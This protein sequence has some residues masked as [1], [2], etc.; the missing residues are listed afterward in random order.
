MMRKLAD[1]AKVCHVE[2]SP[3]L[4]AE[5]GP[6]RLAVLVEGATEPPFHNEHW[7]RHEMGIYLDALDGTPLFASAAKYD[8]G[9]GWPSFWAP[10]DPELLELVEDRSHGMRRIEVRAKK[11]GGHLG[12]LFDDGPPPSGQRYCLNSAS[13]RFV[14]LAEL[15]GA[16]LGSLAALFGTEPLHEGPENTIVEP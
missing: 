4:R 13:L 10:L 9:T 2:I 14:P 12:H 6:Q 5:L 8:S 7:N 11:S 3:K 1:S 16:G 15:V